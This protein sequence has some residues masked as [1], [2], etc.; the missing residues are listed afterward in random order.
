MP[1]PLIDDTMPR[2]TSAKSGP[3]IGERLKRLLDGNQRHGVEL[4]GGLLLLSVLLLSFIAISDEIRDADTIALDQRVLLA[5]RGSSPSDPVGPHWF[6]RLWGDWTALG[7]A[8]IVGLLCTVLIVYLLLFRQWR[9]ALWVFFVVNG[10]WIISDVLKSAF[11]RPRPD[12]AFH[13]VEVASQSFPSGHS[14]TAA[15]IYPTLGIL[16]GRLVPDLR[17]KLYVWATALF[18]MVLVGLSRIYL[19]VHYLSDVLGGWSVGLAWA[20][21]C[22]LVTRVL[23]RQG[24]LEPPRGSAAHE[25]R[26]TIEPP[27]ASPA[28]ERTPA[29]ED[30]AGGLAPASAAR[31]LED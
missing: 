17:R 11:D 26:G 23:E 31:H 3:R 9:N 5:L 16:L 7:G 1:K 10:C 14:L 21:A 12:H 8:P 28:R 18:V 2:V 13:A 20:I 19:G 22:Y 29:P 4:Y 24:T 15:A 27:G 6:E 30:T 25:R